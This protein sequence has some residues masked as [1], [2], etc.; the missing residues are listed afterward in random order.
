MTLHL[1]RFDSV[2]ACVLA[3]SDLVDRVAIDQVHWR[4]AV[5]RDCEQLPARVHLPLVC[6]EQ[7]VV[8]AARGD[9]ELCGTYACLCA[10]LMQ[11]C[12]DRDLTTALVPWGFT[13]ARASSR[14]VPRRACAGADRLERTLVR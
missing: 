3:L 7:Q 4:L 13:D 9:C 5:G 1:Y 6:N 14:P 10:L 2:L 8:C 11:D 12:Y